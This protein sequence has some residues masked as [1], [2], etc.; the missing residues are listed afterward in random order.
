MMSSSVWLF[1]VLLGMRHALE[2]DHLAAVSTM[3][4]EQRRATSGAVLGGMWGLGHTLALLL[5]ATVLA[6]LGA[7]M[8]PRLAIIFELGVAVMLIAIGVRSM[9]R[10][11][12]EHVHG[13]PPAPGGP[14]RFARRS[15]VVGSIHGLAGSGALTALIASQLPSTPGRLTYVALFGLG[16]VVGMALLSGI[17]GW[18]L[19]R[20]GRSPVLARALMMATGVLAVGLGVVWGLPLVRALIS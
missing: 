13:A 8:P 18:P 3:V 6:A 5:V 2:P 11:P 16:S 7:A 17:A 4:V 15:L 14:F 20:L 1:G 10:A 9:A 12:R 19:A